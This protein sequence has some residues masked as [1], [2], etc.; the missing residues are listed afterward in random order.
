LSNLIAAKPGLVERFELFTV[1]REHAN[2]FSEL[3]DPVDQRQRFE[4][5]Q[6]QRRLLTKRPAMWTKNSFGHSGKECHQ[7][8]DLG[9]GIDRY[10]AAGSSIRDV[11]T[12]PLLRP[13]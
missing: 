13:E 3:T 10:D 7:R 9:I 4:A 1:G 12:F 11:I 8:V 2:S 5:Q 6:R